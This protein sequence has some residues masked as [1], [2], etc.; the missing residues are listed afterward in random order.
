[1]GFNNIWFVLFLPVVLILYFLL[2]HKLRWPFL[3]GSSYF[4]YGFF[5][6]FY[7][8]IMVIVT[9]ISYGTGLLLENY[10]K[11]WLA[12]IGVLGVVSFLIFFKYMNW[13]VQIFNDVSGLIHADWTWSMRNIILPIGIS[14]YTFQAISYIIDIYRGTIKAEKHI[15]YFSLYICYFPQLVAGP[16]EKPAFLIPQ[17]KDKAKLQW[18]NFS[19]GCKLLLLGFFKK[20]V[21]AE[22]LFLFASTTIDEATLPETGGFEIAIGLLAYIY[23]L[24]NDFSAYCDIAM[25][26]SRIM[27]IRLSQ[28]FLKPFSSTNCRIFWNRWHATLSVWV[29][30][31]IFKPLG[32]VIKGHQI[33]TLVNVFV[34]FAIMGIWH[35]ASYNFLFFGLLAGFYVI[36][37]FAT[38][39]WRLKKYKSW[40][41]NLKSL[42]VKTISRVIV[43]MTF[44]SLGIFFFTPDMNSAL[45][46]IEKL[47]LIFTNV[48][49]HLYALIVVIGLITFTE[50][51]NFFTKK[52]ENHPFNY[53]KNTPLRI[54]SYAF[55][56]IIILIFVASGSVDFYYLRF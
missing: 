21:I 10:R 23:F 42:W 32:G 14:F 33:R 9:L 45:I 43:V 4:F 41:I 56:T 8:L 5:E 35:G 24:Y 7:I 54:F 30:D 55:A 37:D 53:V 49:I 2:P 51:I 52:G 46:I 27:G 17:F 22:N 1:M 12:A 13:I 16:I 20:I 31:Y 25:G 36:V 40:G 11:K 38:K 48:Q 29:R 47:F 6:P 26:A 50:L 28:N 18:E 19:E 3:I 34:A 15:G 44:M 39:K